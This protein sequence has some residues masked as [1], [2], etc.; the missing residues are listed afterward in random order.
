MSEWVVAVLPVEAVRPVK[1]VVAKGTHAAARVV[2]NSFRYPMTVNPPRTN[3]AF[4]L[5]VVEPSPA[6]PASPP[7]T[8][9]TASGRAD[10]VDAVPI[11]P[12]VTAET[13]KV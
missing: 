13:R 11:P 6:T 12:A 9:A 5:S 8:S 3:G 7:T 4:Q 1:E 2:H 10:T